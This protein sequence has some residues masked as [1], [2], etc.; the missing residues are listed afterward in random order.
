MAN[1][2]ITETY[3]HGWNILAVGWLAAGAAV[4]VLAWFPA[5][6]LFGDTLVAQMLAFATGGFAMTCGDL[7]YR[8]RNSES[9]NLWRFLAHFAGGNFLFIPSWCL[10]LGVIALAALYASGI[11]E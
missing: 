10:G 7:I 11:I 2:E 3:H 4:A 6:L 9:G 5:S 1:R 8:F